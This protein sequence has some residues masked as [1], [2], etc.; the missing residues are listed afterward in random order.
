ML[1]VIV[2]IIP[3]ALDKN[4]E[5]RDVALDICCN[6][7]SDIINV[8]NGCIQF[9]YIIFLFYFFMI[10]VRGSEPGL[11]QTAEK[12]GYGSKLLGNNRFKE[13]NF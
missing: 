6:N 9:S 10:N 11:R 8:K 5:T 1:T 7:N 2:Q 3:Q 12:F 13:Y 4:C